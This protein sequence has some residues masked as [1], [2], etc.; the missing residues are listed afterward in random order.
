MYRDLE[1]VLFVSENVEQYQ[2]CIS[3]PRKYPIITNQTF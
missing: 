3:A 1:T 2:W